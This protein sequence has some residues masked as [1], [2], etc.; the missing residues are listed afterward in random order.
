MPTLGAQVASIVQKNWRRIFGFIGVQGL[1]DLVREFVRGKAMEWIYQNLG[2]VGIWMASYKL[3]GLT[4]GIIIVILW[5]IASVI[6]ATRERESIILDPT[7]KPYQIRTAPK[8]WARS[9]VVV[10]CALVIFLVYGTYRFYR[11]TPQILLEKY[12]LGYVVFDVDQE[13]A[14]FPYGT[15]YLLD[16]WDFDWSTVKM[17]T[18]KMDNQDVVWLTLP[19]IRYKNGRGLIMTDSHVGWPKRVG[20]IGNSVLRTPNFDMRAE[21]LAIGPK[22]IV[23]LIGF[24]QT[25]MH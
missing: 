23:F 25:P 7:G 11:V 17:A 16:R 1:F 19:N 14:I 2:S 6:K 21:I 13:N 4:I 8:A 12:P 9:A 20:P 15:K 10:S 18:G 22:G 3:A 24:A 5:L